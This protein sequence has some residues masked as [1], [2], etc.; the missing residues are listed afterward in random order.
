V[1]FERY[2]KMILCCKLRAIGKFE[3]RFDFLGALPA[4]DK[5]E[6]SCRMVCIRKKL[7][8]KQIDDYYLEQCRCKAVRS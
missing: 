2:A 1:L 5:Y 8:S 7:L 4:S 6:T 3:Q